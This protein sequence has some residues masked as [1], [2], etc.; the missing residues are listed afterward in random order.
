MFILSPRLL[1]RYVPSLPTILLLNE[2]FHHDQIMNGVLPYEDRWQTIINING[3]VRPPRPKPGY[4]SKGQWIEDPVWDVITAGWH[5]EPE[6]R[7]E[8]AV[9][10]HVFLTHSSP[11]GQ[12]VVTGESS[13]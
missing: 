6:Q 5:H 12:D 4:P 9:V 10:Y 11:V 2:N 7:C 3:G 8:L 13:S 1:S